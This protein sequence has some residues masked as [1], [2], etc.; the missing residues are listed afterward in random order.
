[1]FSS[2]LLYRRGERAPSQLSAGCD[3]KVHGDGLQ[4]P[5]PVTQTRL[6]RV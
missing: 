5:M 4:L 2:G 3:V 1:M 6:R